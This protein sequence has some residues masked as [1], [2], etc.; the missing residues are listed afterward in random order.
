MG[1]Q[2]V[3]GKVLLTVSNGACRKLVAGA[4]NIVK[5]YARSIVKW[6]SKSQFGLFRVILKCFHYFHYCDGP[7]F[8]SE[9][10]CGT[11]IYATDLAAQIRYQLK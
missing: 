5:I 7:W 6:G 3:F 1:R 8:L 10:H 9:W 11:Q 2:T 4:R